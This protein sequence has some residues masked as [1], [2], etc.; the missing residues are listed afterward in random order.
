DFFSKQGNQPKPPFNRKIWGGSI[1]GPLHLPRFGEGGPAYYKTGRKT[2]FFFAVER[3]A[4]ATS[5]PV[6]P[7]ALA[8][9]TLVQSL[10]AVPSSI[11][12]TP[13]HDWRVNP[14][15]D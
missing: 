15:L 10:G 4:E 8:E 6:A 7:Y 9:L 2:F 5:I 3:Q 1:G 11:I 12:P 13:Y 14:R